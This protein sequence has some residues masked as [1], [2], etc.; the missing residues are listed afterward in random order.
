[1]IIV[2][3]KKD[4]TILEPDPSDLLALD[5]IVADTQVLVVW[6]KTYIHAYTRGENISFQWSTNHGSLIGKDSSSVQYYGCPTCVGLNTVECTISNEYGTISDTIMIRSGE[7]H[8][9]H[10]DAVVFQ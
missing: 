7:N 8:S 1:M 10:I 9:S 3:C 5:S 2:S 4:E 6:Q